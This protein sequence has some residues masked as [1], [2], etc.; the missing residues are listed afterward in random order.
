MLE[1]QVE[2]QSENRVIM[3]LDKVQ[4]EMN[5][6]IFGF[7]AAFHRAYLKYEKKKMG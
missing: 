3:A 4:K 6:D 2:K 1:Q 7:S 5:V